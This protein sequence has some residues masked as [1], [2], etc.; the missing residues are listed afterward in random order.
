MISKDR[1]GRKD[2]Y[3]QAR[4]D[5]RL[6][7]SE[8]GAGIGDVP[9]PSGGLQRMDGA[10]A[11]ET[12]LGE[13]GQWQW[14]AAR[15]YGMAAAAHPV[16]ILGPDSDRTGPTGVAFHEREIELAAFEIAAQLDAQITADV[17]PEPGP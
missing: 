1:D 14:I 2:A 3:A 15:V 12:A 16:K 4:R 11:I 6:N 5:R 10:I 13:H 9:S 8:V 7:A 17:E